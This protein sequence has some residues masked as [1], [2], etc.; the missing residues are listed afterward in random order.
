MPASPTATAPSTRSR[1]TTLA[2][3]ASVRVRATRRVVRDL[4]A[5]PPLEPSQLAEIRAAALRLRVLGGA[6]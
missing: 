1:D 3:E 6:R 5:L 2:T 4:A